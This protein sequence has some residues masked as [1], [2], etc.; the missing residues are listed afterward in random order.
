MTEQCNYIED[1]TETEQTRWEYTL[2]GRTLTAPD[3]TVWKQGMT[4]DMSLWYGIPTRAGRV[5]V[6]RSDA[7]EFAAVDLDNPHDIRGTL[8]AELEVPQDHRPP[9]PAERLITYLWYHGMTEAE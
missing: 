2:T 1:E 5:E 8:L 3:N 4:K 9:L 6:W 7:G